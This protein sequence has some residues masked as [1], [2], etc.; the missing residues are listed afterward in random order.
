MAKVN[1]AEFVEQVRTEARKVTWPTRRE[2]TQTTV[3]VLIMT[4]MLSVFFLGVDQ[5][6]GRGVKL[7]LSVAS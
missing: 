6:V 7:L 1:P 2:V 5:I 4:S 3:M